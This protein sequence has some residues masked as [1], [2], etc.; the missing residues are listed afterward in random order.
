MVFAVPAIYRYLYGVV[1]LTLSVDSTS[2]LTQIKP[3]P[4]HI[5]YPVPD[6]SN[7]EQHHGTCSN[8]ETQRRAVE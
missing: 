8:P 5:V 4:S 6:K 3:K 1:N 2:P 7:Q